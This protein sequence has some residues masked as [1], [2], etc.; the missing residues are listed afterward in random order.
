M[1]ANLQEWITVVATALLHFV[2]QGFVI[3]ALVA[4]L[5]RA[6]RRAPAQ[7]RYL[8]S[9]LA[10][11][12]CLLLP[13]IYLIQN[14]PAHDVVSIALIDNLPDTNA[15]AT[16]SLASENTNSIV[17]SAYV[18]WQSQWSSLKPLL[19]YL[20]AL[21]TAGVCILLLRMMLGLRWVSQQVKLAKQLSDPIW[22]AKLQSMANTMGVKQRLRLGIS[23]QLE[24]P[25]TAGWWRPIVILPAS[26]VSGMPAELLEA[27]L[28]HEVAHIKR[29]DYFMNLL[30][31]LIEVV[32]FYHPA[33]WWL[34]KQIRIER[35]QIADDLAASLLGEP[36][37]LALALSEL[38]RFQFTHPQLAQVAHGGN[39]MLRIKRLIQ[40]DSTVK[41]AGWKI[42]LPGLGLGAAC[43]ALYAQANGVPSTAPIAVTSAATV[44]AS[45]PV[46]VSVSAPV[47]TPSVPHKHEKKELQFALVKPAD[48]HNTFV[49]S[50]KRGLAEIEKLRKEN[51][52]DFLWFSEKGTSY[53]IKDPEI[54]GQA[55]A[56]YKPMEA[57]GEQMEQHGKK[58]EAQGAVMEEI[59]EQMQAISDKQPQIDDKLNARF[60]AKMRDYEKKVAAFELKMEAA[61]EKVEKASNAQMRQHALEQL[62]KEQGKFQLLMKELQK[63]DQLYQQHHQQIEQSLQPLQAMS[64]KMEEAAKPM[65]ALGAQMEQLGKQMESLS[66]QAEKQIWGLIQTAKQKGLIEPV[67]S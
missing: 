26:L 52:Q 1:N 47:M 12:F 46:P 25:V 66:Q 21:W 8:L 16:S 67:K 32:L 43:L 49:N 41:T 55:N 40:A 59:G 20:V 15:S 17:H 63:N 60:E 24:F 62:S 9:S 34:S 13:L 61:A 45:S 56:A 6:L 19:P 29:F 23:T 54:I 38:E 58:M 36:R 10:L 42:V 53:L 51:K 64:K 30:Q 14:A 4:V 5:L 44:V 31:S 22:Q 18:Q 65:E 39:L 37:R 48:K 7:T 28:A 3:A 35:E 2:W 33:V 50:D 57:L 11:G 27:L